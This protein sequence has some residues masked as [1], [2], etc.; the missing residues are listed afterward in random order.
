MR[1]AKLLF[2]L[3]WLLPEPS[4]ASLNPVTRIVASTTHFNLDDLYQQAYE[5]THWN[6]SLLAMDLMV[7]GSSMRS[8]HA[9]QQA[10]TM[11]S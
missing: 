9:L 11:V 4:F 5:L 2:D 8:F 10:V 3:A 6:H 7:S 1:Q